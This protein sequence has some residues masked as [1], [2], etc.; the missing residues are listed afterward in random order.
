M[1]LKT[2]SQDTAQQHSSQ[3]YTNKKIY[4]FKDRQPF[5][6]LETTIARNKG[7][8]SFANANGSETKTDG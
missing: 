7:S 5:G 8:R 3:A 6:N 4:F 1:K 2:A